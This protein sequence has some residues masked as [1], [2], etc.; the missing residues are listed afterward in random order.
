MKA[1]FKDV[2]HCLTGTRVCSSTWTG[3]LTELFILSQ[4]SE[5]RRRMFTVFFNY[6][7]CHV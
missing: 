5:Q 3:R 1:Q 4:W 7:L 2:L 6:H